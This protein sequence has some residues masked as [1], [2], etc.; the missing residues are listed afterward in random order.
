LLYG[1]NNAEQSFVLLLFPDDGIPQIASSLQYDFHGM[2]CNMWSR[3]CM[4]LLYYHTGEWTPFVMHGV[5][6]KGVSRQDIFILESFNFLMIGHNSCHYWIIFYIECAHG[7][8]CTCL[9]K[10]GCPFVNT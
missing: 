6:N 5:V 2:M 7:L 3:Q 10:D 9:R 4:I 8:P 1:T